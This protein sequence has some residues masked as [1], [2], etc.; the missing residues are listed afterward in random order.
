[1]EQHMELA[2]STWQQ[3]EEYLKSSQTVL[4]PIGST[5]Q[6]GPTGIFCT[7]Y[8][9][10]ERISIEAGERTGALVTP[11]IS[12]GMSNHHLAFAGTI[13]LNPS[14]LMKVVEDVVSSLQGGGFR[15][16]LFVNGH[17]GNN[18]TLDAT[19][20]EIRDKYTDAWL[21]LVSWYKMPAVQKKAGEL[22]GEGE[23][24]HAT[25]SEISVTMYIFPGLLRKAPKFDPKK[26]PL[27][28]MPS[29]AQF[30]EM[31]PDG[32]M[33][34]DPSL[35]SEEHGKTLFELAVE[36]LVKEIKDLGK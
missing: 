20:S 21:Q 32:R 6:H 9:I 12:L 33:W 25:P 11:V 26:V 23:G 15:K 5:E 8:V 2:K 30:R 14:T 3:V 13:S 4:I 34:S 7:D 17:G 27:K 31:F 22:F 1:M 24:S 19:F 18:S 35:A 16:F 36:E 10:P 28:Q 29:S